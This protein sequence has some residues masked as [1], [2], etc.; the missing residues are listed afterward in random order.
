MSAGQRREGPLADINDLLQRR[1][2]LVEEGRSVLDAAEK[3]DRNLTDEEQSNYDARFSEIA[4]LT[5]RI[6]RK[7]QQIEAEA[8]LE[9]ATEREPVERP[10]VEER[11]TET[12][13]EERQK[14]LD[15]EL[16]SL[17]RTGQPGPELR[18]LSAGVDTEGG[19]TV[20]PQFLA[21]LI[22]DVDDMVFIR[23]R[24][25]VRS[26][27]MGESLGIPT[28]ESR[29]DDAD[30]TSELATGSEDTGLSYGERELRPH[31]L[32][33]RIKVSRKLVRSSAIDIV[34]E[35]RGQL[36]YKFGITE[37]KGF[38]TGSGAGQPLGVFTASADGISTSRDVSSGNT[39][40]S[41]TFDGLI[42]AK[43]S[44]KGAYW[45]S[46][47]WLFHRDALSQIE[48][49][50]DG[51]G[52]YL[53]QPSKQV[54]QPDMILGRPFMM[55]EYVPNTFTSGQYVGIL[56]DFS[57]YWIVDALMMSV[58]VLNE[59][60]AETNQV[61]YIGRL[62]TDGMPVLEEAFARVKLG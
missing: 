9:R 36:A 44:L 39:G 45:N 7:R 25:T 60:Y 59:L 35:V 16:R 56:G 53:W 15:A 38:L 54:G 19:Y 31:P 10:A 46:A 34:S 57:N 17:F 6:E 47:D 13:E 21:Q 33:K 5:E 52:Q 37:E 48:K 24:A 43:Y 61:G 8:T 55:S 32:A 2:K 14:K 23:Q 3:E 40:T 26:L 27:G 28:R 29:V 22:T 58:Q 30:W 49:L 11:K 4:D 41:I 12:P 1:A 18:N 42:N 62:E 50:K 51:E 20:P